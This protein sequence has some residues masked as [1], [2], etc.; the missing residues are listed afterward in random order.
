MDQ[1]LCIGKKI[2]KH[3]G[4]KKPQRVIRPSAE[5]RI[6]GHKERL[7]YFLFNIVGFVFAS[8]LCA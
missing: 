6:G 1:S 8:C 5:I 4:T 2:F 7:K 3:K